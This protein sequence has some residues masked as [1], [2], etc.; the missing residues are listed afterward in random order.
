MA[1]SFKVLFAV[2]VTFVG[3]CS[4]SKTSQLISVL[5]KDAD[6][7][8]LIKM[9]TSFNNSM[10]KL[11][12]HTFVNLEENVVHELCQKPPC[13]LWSNWSNCTANGTD[14]FG[15]QTRVRKCWYN[16]T[17]ACAHDG[18]VT[19][20]TASKVCEGGH[21]QQTC[22]RAYIRTK[23]GFCIKYIATEL[24]RAGAVKR[25]QSEGANIMNI[26]T[27]ER[28]IDHANLL[29]NISSTF[30]WVDGTR[31]NSKAPWSFR[32]GTDPTKN[33]VVQWG[34]GQPNSNKDNLCLS[35]TIIGGKASYYAGTC[36]LSRHVLCE[37]RK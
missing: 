29:S 1:V 23:H 26:D 10:L 4:A 27:K 5:R 8:N 14:A 11:I 28:W 32:V 22:G 24:T 31:Q 30:F 12:G 19:I 13:T 34:V 21:V 33:G 9:G 7:E 17:D 18:P 3:Y 16:S 37:I 2:F 15:F 36:V 6:G 35:G 20:E 25:C